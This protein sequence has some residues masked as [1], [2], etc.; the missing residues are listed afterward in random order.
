MIMRVVRGSVVAVVVV[1][2]Y[3]RSATFNVHVSAAYRMQE[4][5]AQRL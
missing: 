3:L 1:V 2:S 4:E 5:T